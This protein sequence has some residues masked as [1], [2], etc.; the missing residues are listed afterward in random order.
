MPI[1]ELNSDI[2]KPDFMQITLSKPLI[3]G[4]RQKLKQ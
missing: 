2:M 4:A 1:S 3:G